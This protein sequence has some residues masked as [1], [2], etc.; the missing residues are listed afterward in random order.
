MWCVCEGVRLARNLV[1]TVSEK[2]TYRLQ[3]KYLVIY[4][5]MF[6]VWLNAATVKSYVAHED[7]MK[8]LKVAL[9]NFKS[10]EEVQT[11]GAAIRQKITS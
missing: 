4:M 10:N 2:I 6:I 11:E 7:A 1:W 8:V 3:L 9:N 5:H